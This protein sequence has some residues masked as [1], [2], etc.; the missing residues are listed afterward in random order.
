MGMTTQCTRPSVAMRGGILMRHHW[1]LQGAEVHCSQL[2]Q[3]RPEGVGSSDGN[4]PSRDKR[5]N[6]TLARDN[7]ETEI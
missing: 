7:S 2:P 4:V 1:I 6:G 3:E 5:S